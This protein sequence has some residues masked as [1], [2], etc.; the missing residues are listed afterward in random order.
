M[1]RVVHQRDRQ[2]PAGAGERLRRHPVVDV[3]ACDRVV[4]EPAHGR[5][6]ALLEVVERCARGACHL[7]RGRRSGGQDV[8]ALVAAQA[9]LGRDRPAG[10]HLVV[11]P[12]VVDRL[13]EAGPRVDDVVGRRRAVRVTRDVLGAAACRRDGADRP[14]RGAQRRIRLH[15]R[16]PVIA[17]RAAGGGNLAERVRR[18]V[19]D[20]GHGDARL[21][22]VDLESRAVEAGVAVSDV[23]LASAGRDLHRRALLRPAGLGER[24]GTRRLQAGPAVG[25]RERVRDRGV[26]PAGRVRIRRRSGVGEP[27]RLEVDHVAADR[28][29]GG[30]VAGGVGDDP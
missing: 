7:N 28:A 30:G 22:R 2:A 1:R 24:G 18:A 11:D 16:P 15:A 3:L 29:R 8:E 5:G 12:V 25:G 6:R 10:V 26:V 21:C 19:G 20:A 4:L 9:E 23:V 17:C 14:T 27:G 13:E